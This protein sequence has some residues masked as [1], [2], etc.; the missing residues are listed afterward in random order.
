M[1]AGKSIQPYGYVV[2]LSTL[3]KFCDDFC[4]SIVGTLLARK[5]S[6]IIPHLPSS[7]LWRQSDSM[8]KKTMGDDDRKV[9]TMET[10]LPVVDK[11]SGAGKLYSRTTSGTA[12]PMETVTFEEAPKS[13]GSFVGKQIVIM[14]HF[15]AGVETWCDKFAVAVAITAWYAVGVLAIVTTK[16]L[17]QDWH[18]PAMALTVQQMVLGTIILRLV[19][20]ARDGAAQPWPWEAHQQQTATEVVQNELF[21]DRMKRHMPWLKHPN[22]VLS[23]VFNSLDFLASNYAFSFSSAHFVETIK[24]S[25]PITTSAIALI[26][27]VDRLSLTEGGSLAMLIAGVLLSTWGNST[28]EN[29]IP[30]DKKLVESIR[31]A[32]LALLANLFFG[33]RAMNQ[34]KYRSTT[35]ETQQM[36]DV[37]FLCRMLQVGTIFL[38]IPL[39][40]LHSSTISEALN[41]PSETLFSYLGLSIVNAFSYVTYK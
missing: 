11:R 27:K 10:Q 32:T 35:H 7:P 12:A 20:A 4:Y 14:H 16:L 3:H 9:D 18:C 30:D 15:K 21:A 19:V 1:K 13:D 17:L 22:F 38:L 31:S 26:W 23:G 34:K 2:V 29:A 40:V 28:D 8:P 39:V 5:V 41:K 37:N 25:E 33:F 36:D 24:A 6:S